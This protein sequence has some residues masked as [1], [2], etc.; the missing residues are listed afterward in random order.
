MWACVAGPLCGLEAD[1][2]DFA[3]FW[4]VVVGHAVREGGSVPGVGGFHLVPYGVPIMGACH[5]DGACGYGG[6]QA[7]VC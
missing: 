7:P 3:N 4:G 1:R 2:G 6:G 5:A